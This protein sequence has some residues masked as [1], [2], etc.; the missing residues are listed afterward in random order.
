VIIIVIMVIHA[1]FFILQLYIYRQ[2]KDYNR[3]RKNFNQPCYKYR[4]SLNKNII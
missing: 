2:V 1:V 4:A 3:W